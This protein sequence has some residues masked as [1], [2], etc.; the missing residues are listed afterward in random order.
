MTAQKDSLRKLRFGFN[1]GVNYSE[2][3]IEKSH[4]N[5]VGEVSPFSGAGFRSGIVLEQRLT[6]R[7]D[8]YP[9]AE[10]SFNSAGVKVIKNGSDEIKYSYRQTMELAPHFK[11]H[12]HDKRRSPYILVGPA[13]K[14]PFT[15]SSNPAKF[16]MHTATVSMDLGFGAGR[17]L[18]FFD[19]LPE[20]RY[21]YGLNNIADMEG[22]RDAR[23]HSVSLILN[24]VT[25]GRTFP[26]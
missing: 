23:F 5:F 17:P 19:L 24:F 25:P 13:L 14:M 2:L 21:S 9:S 12:L 26:Q 15:F 11:F 6:R 22:V 1:L 18:K 16:N 10:L 7:V 3:Q 4:N 8:F 20:L